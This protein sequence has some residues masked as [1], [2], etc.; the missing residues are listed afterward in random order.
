MTAIGAAVNPGENLT[1]AVARRLRGQLAE[2]R[3]SQLVLCEITGW[4]RMYIGRRLSGET[5]MDIADLERTY[6]KCWYPG[7]GGGVA[8]EYPHPRDTHCESSDIRKWWPA[9][10]EFQPK[11]E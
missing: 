5:P 10:R 4:G 11:E 9:C 1:Q 7:R 2:L 8:D 3:I 6:P